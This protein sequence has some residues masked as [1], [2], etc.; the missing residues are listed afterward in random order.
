VGFDPITYRAVRE[1]QRVI[2]A[3]HQFNYLH[4]GVALGIEVWLE[5]FVGISLMIGAKLKIV[6]IHVLKLEGVFTALARRCFSTGEE[7]EKRERFL[8]SA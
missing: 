7:R 6:D 3:A 8:R 1:A 4:M 5:G 2:K